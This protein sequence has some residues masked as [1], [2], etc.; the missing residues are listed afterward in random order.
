MKGIII[1]VDGEWWTFYVVLEL[2]DGAHWDVLIQFEYGAQPTNRSDLSAF[3][4]LL[5][6]FDRDSG[7][8]HDFTMSENKG[9]TG[10]KEIPFYFKKNMIDLKYRNC[11]MKGLYPN[12]STHVEDDEK[13]FILDLSLN[14]TSLPHWSAQEGSN[15]Y[16]P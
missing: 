4:L 13:T 15:G 2:E 3:L 9:T 11:T 6:C 5:Y 16:F 10:G 1:H 14:A 8:M 7:K 12:Y